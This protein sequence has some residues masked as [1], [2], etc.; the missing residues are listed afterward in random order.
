[1]SEIGKERR[2]ME[3]KRLLQLEGECKWSWGRGGLPST[4]YIQ[5]LGKNYLVDEGR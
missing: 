3:Y 4:G 1:M 5:C 2:N